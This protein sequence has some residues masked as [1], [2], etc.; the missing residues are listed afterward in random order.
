MNTRR[1]PTPTLYYHYCRLLSFSSYFFLCATGKIPRVYFYIYFIFR[2]RE[3]KG[4]LASYDN[5][6]Y[7]TQRIFHSHPLKF[8]PEHFPFFF[9]FRTFPYIYFDFM[10][11]DQTV[12]HLHFDKKK[13][14]EE[15]FLWRRLLTSERKRSLPE[16]VFSFS[17]KTSC[18]CN[19]TLILLRKIPWRRCWIFHT[20]K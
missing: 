16:P 15:N 10:R 1:S 3:L 2:R 8:I 18:C 14:Q 13:K 11:F 9:I 5:G 17:E 20:N 7:L 19:F 4:G 12:N 6:F